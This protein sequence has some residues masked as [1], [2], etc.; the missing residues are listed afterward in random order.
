[1]GIVIPVYN[2]AHSYVFKLDFSMISVAN[3]SMKLFWKM[4]R[5]AAQ[6]FG[7]DFFVMPFSSP[8]FC[9]GLGCTHFMSFYMEKIKTKCIKLVD[10]F[11]KETI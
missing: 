10:M 4:P 1:M 3:S 7:F 6:M 9:V 2:V 5:H 8:S 11:R